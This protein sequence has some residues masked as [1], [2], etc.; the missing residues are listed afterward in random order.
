M[1]RKSSNLG[2]RPPGWPRPDR[3][4]LREW[5][6]LYE[7]FVTIIKPCHVGKWLDTPNEAFSGLKPLDLI[8]RFELN[9]LMR[10]IFEADSGILT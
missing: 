7:T 10:M 1:G 9:W 5:K 6:R 3:K 4:S 2:T 8:A